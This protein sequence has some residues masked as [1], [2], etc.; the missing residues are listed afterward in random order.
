MTPHTRYL[1][2]FITLWSKTWNTL[3]Y[4]ILTIESMRKYQ[5]GWQYEKKCKE[6][7]T[8]TETNFAMYL[9]LKNAIKIEG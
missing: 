6:V 4:E 9:E 3:I 8:S 7:E 2:V 5:V 1:D